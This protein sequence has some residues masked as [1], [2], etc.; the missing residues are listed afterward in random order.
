[1]RRLI[2]IVFCVSLL[3]NFQFSV[4][5]SLLAQGLWDRFYDGW[6][7][8][9]RNV[10][11]NYVYQQPLGFNVSLTGNLS[12]QSVLVTNRIVSVYGSNTTDGVVSNKLQE[13]L[14]RNVGFLVGFGRLGAGWSFNLDPAE[15]QQ[16]STFQFS[17]RGNKWGVNLNYL[18]FSQLSLNHYDVNSVSSGTPAG[19]SF[20]DTSADAS[21]MERF[22]VDAYYVINARR[23]AYPPGIAGNMVQLKS[24]GGWMLAARYMRGALDIK[25]EINTGVDRVG[26]DQ[27]SLGCGYSYTWVLY[28]R[29]P[30]DTKSGKGMRTF[31]VNGTVMPM[32][33]LFNHLSVHPL[34]VRGG[35]R[36]DTEPREF[37]C[38]PTPNV[39]AN[40]TVGYSWN[41]FYVGAMLAFNVFHYN[42]R[43]SVSAV[44]VVEA[45]GITEFGTMG[46]FYEW[47]LNL[48]M[49]VSF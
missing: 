16:L 9:P 48:K 20:D 27:V 36:L 42:S 23:F 37:F 4:F 5:N 32:L 38:W 6:L 35:A 44:D 25:H 2:K 7:V 34:L 17:F 8:M 18:A 15:E 12:R 13:N 45:S 39:L 46:V 41:R 49:Q 19:F 10:D 24:A 43:N 11:S 47:N 28:S 26:M 31:F 40:A 14:Y 33:T 30:I 22:T 29:R 21:R 3:F 1:M